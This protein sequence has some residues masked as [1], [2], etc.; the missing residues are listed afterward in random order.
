MQSYTYLAAESW[1]FVHS[2]IYYHFFI[3][4]SLITWSTKCIKK[5]GSWSGKFVR[6][7][8]KDFGIKAVSNLFIKV[9]FMSIENRM[10]LTQLYQFFL[11]GTWVTTSWT[12]CHKIF[13]ATILTWLGCKLRL[14]KS[15]LCAFQFKR[16]VIS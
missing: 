6:R 10:Y 8:N 14:N 3:L 5:M 7:W 16:A 2:W 4:I 15:V 13:S 9:S 11:T 1:L 12:T